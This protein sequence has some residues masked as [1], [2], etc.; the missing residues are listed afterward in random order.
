MANGHQAPGIGH[1]AAEPSKS[2]RQEATVKK[3]SSSEAIKKRLAAIRHQALGIRP[4]SHREAIV[5]KKII[6]RGHQKAASGHQALGIRHQA[7]ESSRSDR[8]EEVIEQGIKQQ[9]SGIRHQAA[10]PSRSDRQEEVIDRG[11]Q[12]AAVEDEEKS[13]W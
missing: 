11:H 8:Q 1:Q 6:E 2:D 5:K 12:K 4:Q 10:E 9:P 3:K 7:A 13:R